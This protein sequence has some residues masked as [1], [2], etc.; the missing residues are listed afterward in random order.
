MGHAASIH[1]HDKENG[2]LESGQIFSLRELI[3]K[4]EFLIADKN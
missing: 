4:A 3:L 2:T 1:L